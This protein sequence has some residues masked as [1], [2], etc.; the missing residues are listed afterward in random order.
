VLPGN[1]AIPLFALSTPVGGCL[2][3]GLDL[4]A[5]ISTLLY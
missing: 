5:S 3:K 4:L 1:Y 2:Q